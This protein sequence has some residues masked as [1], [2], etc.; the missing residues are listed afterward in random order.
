METGRALITEV[1]LD[2]ELCN[3]VYNLDTPPKKVRDAAQRSH[4]DRR[5][6]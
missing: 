6:V 5:N 3:D 4:R 2:I 1:N